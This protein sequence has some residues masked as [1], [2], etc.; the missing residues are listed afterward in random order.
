[1]FSQK[2]LDPGYVALHI[3]GDNSKREEGSKNAWRVS[4]IHS[5]IE[6]FRRFNIYNRICFSAM[7]AIIPISKELTQYVICD[8]DIYTCVCVFQPETTISH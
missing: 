8:I 2:S 5:N 7:E 6:I 1:M 3:E 4:H